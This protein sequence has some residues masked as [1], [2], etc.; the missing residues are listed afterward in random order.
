MTVPMERNP[1]IRFNRSFVVWL[2]W[3]VWFVL[4]MGYLKFLIVD[5]KQM[6]S[7]TLYLL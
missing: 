5:L 2:V 3:L 6:V 1:I 7:P 4:Y